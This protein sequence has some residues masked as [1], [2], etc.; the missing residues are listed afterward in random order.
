MQQQ[1]KESKQYQVVYPTGTQTLTAT[2]LEDLVQQVFLQMNPPV[3]EPTSIVCPEYGKLP[4]FITPFHHYFA[5]G[6]ISE[7]EFLSWV[8]ELKKEEVACA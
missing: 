5:E 4:F 2:S 1:S 8:S 7:T 6:D 3:Q